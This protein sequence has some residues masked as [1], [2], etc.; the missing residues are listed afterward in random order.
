M[1]KF[2]KGTSGNP[3]GKKPGTLNKRTQL[4]RQFEVYADALINKTVELALSGDPTALRLCIERL[5]PKVKDKS[6]AVVM[7]YVSGMGTTKIIPELLQSLSGQEI[8]ITDFKSLMEIFVAHDTEV[9]RIERQHEELKL[10]TKDPNEA[11]KIYAQ[12]MQR[13]Y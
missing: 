5:V 6:A 1:A 7:P 11:A 8:T 10:D 9:D 13:S 4:T 3:S 2:Q 12:F